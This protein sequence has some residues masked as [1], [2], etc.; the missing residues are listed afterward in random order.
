[1][2]KKLVIGVIVLLVGLAAIGSLI[3]QSVSEGKQT[4]QTQTDPS[5]DPK[6]IVVKAVNKKAV[7]EST[8][9]YFFDIRNQGT[10]PFV[11]KVKIILV[12]KNGDEVSDQ[13]FIL[14]DPIEPGLGVS[15]YY[16]SFYG[17]D[18]IQSFKWISTLGVY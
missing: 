1:M 12:T 5:F 14:S 16:D 3:D 11:G 8:T 4:A 2:L 15:R 7:N 18:E 13:T 9:R 10:I 6:N 17:P